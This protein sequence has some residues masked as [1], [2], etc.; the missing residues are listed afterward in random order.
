MKSY[1]TFFLSLLI[2]SPAK[3]FAETHFMQVLAYVYQHD[4]RLAAEREALKALDQQ[5]AVA[6][7]GFRPNAFGEIDYGRRRSEIDDSGY[8]SG[9]TRTSSVVIE[10]QLFNGFGTQAKYDAAKARVEAGRSRLILKEEQVLLEAVSAYLNLAE[11][12]RLLELN[13]TNKRNIHTQFRGA[14]RR[15]ETGDGT[16]TEVAQS[17]SRLAEA[18]SSLAAAQADWEKAYVAFERSTGVGADAIDFPELTGALPATPQEA[19][20]RALAAPEIA[21]S[22]NE[23]ETGTHEVDVASASIW[24]TLSLRG[25]LG[26][27]EGTTAAGD[28]T[29]REQRITLNLRVPLYQGGAEYARVRAAKNNRQRLEYEVRDT[30]RAA[31][32]RALQLWYAYQASARIIETSKKSAE[33]AAHALKGVEAERREGLRTLIDV[34]DA[35]SELLARQTSQVRA[36]KNYRQDAYRL[37]AAIGGLT[38]EELA[39]NAPSYDPAIHYEDNA[40]S[41]V[42]F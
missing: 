19:R 10:E 5:V 6:Y 25:S 20:E 3:L 31:A 21:L 29:V 38:A 42:G 7:S 28:S 27:E 4:P 30:E 26:E 14:T 36:E 33:S 2:L 23:E 11:K 16:R 1:K 13:F 17:E 18:E 32:E 34:L 22:V 35:Q 41:W 9:T 15:F 40:T 39:L 37:L 12:Q 8:V 24:P